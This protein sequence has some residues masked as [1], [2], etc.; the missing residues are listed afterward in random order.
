METGTVL[1]NLKIH[2]NYDKITQ[3]LFMDHE[4]KLSE[5]NDAN[6]SED[7]IFAYDE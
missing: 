2:V 5:L 6:D 4:M 7:S 1:T 3:K